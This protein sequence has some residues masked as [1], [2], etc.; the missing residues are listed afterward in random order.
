MLLAKAVAIVTAFI[1]KNNI[2]TAAAPDSDASLDVDSLVKRIQSGDAESFDQLVLHFQS[3]VTG[4]LYRFASR[5]AEAH[6]EN[7]D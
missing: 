7:P 1:S 4:L 2:L 5:P 3:L 6:L